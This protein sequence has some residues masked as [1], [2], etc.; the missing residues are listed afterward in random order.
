MDYGSLVASNLTN[1]QKRGDWP[2][3]GPEPVEKSARPA[4][5]AAF[6]HH[7]QRLF[8]QKFSASRFAQFQRGSMIGKART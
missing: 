1:R 2:L 6:W 3:Y 5:L 7:M 8:A 4:K